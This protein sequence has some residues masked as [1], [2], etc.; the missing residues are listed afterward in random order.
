[1]H[2]IE[3]FADNAM[4][5]AQQQIQNKFKNTLLLA[6]QNYTKTHGAQYWAFLDNDMKRT[7]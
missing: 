7:S 4:K 6:L 2:T 5:T 3:A 1:M